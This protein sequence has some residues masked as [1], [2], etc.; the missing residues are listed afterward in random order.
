M[1]L[2]PR[3]RIR[4]YE[5]AA[6]AAP[7]QQLSVLSTPFAAA[8]HSLIPQQAAMPPSAAAA[9][10]YN[11]PLTITPPFVTGALSSRTTRLRPYPCRI[12]GA[13]LSS[14]SNRVRHERSRHTTAAPTT[15][16]PVCNTVV[17]AR[18]GSASVSVQPS[19]Q[20]SLALPSEIASPLQCGLTALGSDVSETQAVVR[21]EV[22]CAAASSTDA[23]WTF[24]HPA[25]CTEHAER[26]LTFDRLHA[27]TVADAPSQP[28]ESADTANTVPTS[29]VPVNEAAAAV[30]TL[31]KVASAP[32]RKTSASPS[33]EPNNITIYREHA[34]SAILPAVGGGIPAS[35]ARDVP[36]DGHAMHPVGM[37]VLSEDELQRNCYRFLECLTQPPMTQVRVARRC[38]RVC[39]PLCVAMLSTPLLS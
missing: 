3:K 8:T 11:G 7:V 17:E 22:D 6:A 18:E 21:M 26:T 35:A 38:M 33:A 30:D 27:D 16:A 31:E 24:S 37:P 4:L 32:I 23:S 15:Q 9:A 19:V 25:L 14:A 2:Q 13:I 36:V 29:N 5:A 39:F 10:A 1:Y 12:C 28:A 20:H 34:P